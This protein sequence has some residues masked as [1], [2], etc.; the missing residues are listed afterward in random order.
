M[1]GHTRIAFNFTVQ[2]WQKE[3]PVG[4]TVTFKASTRDPFDFT[5]IEV[6]ADHVIAGTSD[7]RS[8]LYLIKPTITSFNISQSSPYPCDD[9]TILVEFKTNTPI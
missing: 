8:P 1:N 6:W 5:T 9:N 4:K 7:V 2:N 3:I